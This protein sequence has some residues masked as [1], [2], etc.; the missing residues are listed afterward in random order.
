MPVGQ[1]ANDKSKKRSA[2]RRRAG[3]MGFRMGPG[4]LE[5]RGA[6][7]L[8]VGIKGMSMVGVPSW[9]LTTEYGVLI[10]KRSGANNQG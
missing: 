4:L 7:G 1:V 3:T 2:R 5:L 10:S 8:P 6:R 9:M